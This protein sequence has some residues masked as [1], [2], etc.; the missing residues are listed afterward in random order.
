MMVV[1]DSKGGEIVVNAT[2]KCTLNLIET[3][4]HI[5]ENVCRYMVKKMG[6]EI[7]SDEPISTI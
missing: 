6:A 3:L 7:C 1:D 2:D 4:A 5:R